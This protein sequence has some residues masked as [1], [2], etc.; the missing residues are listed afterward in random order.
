MHVEVPIDEI[1]AAVH[2]TLESIREDASLIA[3]EKLAINEANAAKL[4]DVAKHKLAEARYR[5][6]IVGSRVGKSI[7][8]ERSELLDFLRRQ[9]E[10]GQR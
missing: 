6:E 5:G 7:I 4:L 8:Y 3:A 2:E 9:R 10:E 1:R